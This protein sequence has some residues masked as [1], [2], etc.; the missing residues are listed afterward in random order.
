MGSYLRTNYRITG[1]ELDDDAIGG[2]LSRDEGSMGSGPGATRWHG[3]FIMGSVNAAWSGGAVV[4]IGA[5][6]AMSNYFGDAYVTILNSGHRL[7]VIAVHQ[8]GTA[9]I[10]FYQWSLSG[11]AINDSGCYIKGYAL[12]DASAATGPSGNAHFAWYGFIVSGP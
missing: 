9:C 12:S 8:I 3:G 11:T 2:G 5:F 7:H 10:Q 6:S 1:K 4:D